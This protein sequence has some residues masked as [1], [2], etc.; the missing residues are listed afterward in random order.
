MHFELILAEL[1]L[2]TEAFVVVQAMAKATVAI[3]LNSSEEV[4]SDG[5]KV[6]DDQG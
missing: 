5:A 2:R 4:V 1:V 6:V 3:P